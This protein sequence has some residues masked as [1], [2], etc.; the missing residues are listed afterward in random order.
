[1]QNIRPQYVKHFALTF[2][3]IKVVGRSAQKTPL[4]WKKKLDMPD[5][6]FFAASINIL[7]KNRRR[8][9]GSQVFITDVISKS[10]CQSAEA[11]LV[12]PDSGE[13]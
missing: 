2:V 13:F 11:A 10:L 7:I 12:W 3:A 1:M 5:P 9:I 8:D 4:N 6:F